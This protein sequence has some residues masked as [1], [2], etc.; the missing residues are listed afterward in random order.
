MS[1]KLD[2]RLR[3]ELLQTSPHQDQIH[4]RYHR[5]FTPVCEDLPFRLASISSV[6]PSLSASDRSR[7]CLLGS[8]L[9]SSPPSR[10]CLLGSS[11]PFSLR[12][13]TRLHRSRPPPLRRL[14]AAFFAIPGLCRISYVR[15][16]LHLVRT[17]DHVSRVAPLFSFTMEN[18]TPNQLVNKLA[19]TIGNA[20][21]RSL[22]LPEPIAII[23][24]DQPIQSAELVFQVRIP[25]SQSWSSM[26]SAFHDVKTSTNVVHDFWED[27]SS[28]LW[29]RAGVDVFSGVRLDRGLLSRATSVLH[30]LAFASPRRLQLIK[31]TA[32]ALPV[33][34]PLSEE[35]RIERQ[36]VAY[37]LRYSLRLNPQDIS[38]VLRHLER[39]GLRWRPF[40]KTTLL[41]CKFLVV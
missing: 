15:I 2:V 27:D 37:F 8:S 20:W 11:L 34:N 33:R 18:L 4:R 29:V 25:D 38:L 22:A 14:D 3:F 28:N 24:P 17:C 5:P 30:D 12:D 19:T 13:H 26:L 23:V 10:T 21:A 41:Q 7:T 1:P 36:Q 9:L 31:L 32:T 16:A 40:S 6:S 39:A 35:V